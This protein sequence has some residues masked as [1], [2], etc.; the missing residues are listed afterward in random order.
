MVV[1][2]VL[3]TYGKNKYI[4]VYYIYDDY[5]FHYVVS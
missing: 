1:N 5:K 3:L 4:L 2:V